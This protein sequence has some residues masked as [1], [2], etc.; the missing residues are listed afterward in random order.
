MKLGFH[1]KTM[2]L[3]NNQ[4]TVLEDDNLTMEEHRQEAPKCF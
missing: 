3:K 4:R 2:T 1:Q